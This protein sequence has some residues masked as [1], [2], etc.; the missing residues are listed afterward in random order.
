MF[1]LNLTIAQWVMGQVG[2]ERLPSVAQ[3]RR[4]E[5]RRPDSTSNGPI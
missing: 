3:V 5:M 2:S 4:R 1:D